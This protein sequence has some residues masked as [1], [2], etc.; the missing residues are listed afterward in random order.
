[1]INLINNKS[2]YQS[3]LELGTRI[4][5][6]QFTSRCTGK[7]LGRAMEVIGSMLSGKT[8]EFDV[9]SLRNYG[10]AEIEMVE[11]ELIKRIDQMGLVG[12]TWSGYVLSYYP[13]KE[14]Q[15]VKETVQK[16]EVK[17]SPFDG[18]ALAPRSYSVVEHSTK[19]EVH[20][21]SLEQSYGKVC[22]TFS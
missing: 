12:F 10:S 21:P 7:T 11:Q 20:V 17:V 2:L 8:Y 5:L 22:R 14:H 3:Q 13:F 16:V 9:R 19:P 1:M 15:D 4:G 18:E 6:E